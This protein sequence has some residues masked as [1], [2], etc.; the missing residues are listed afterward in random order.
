VT[1]AP[2]IILA[3]SLVLAPICAAGLILAP[4]RRS[5]LLLLLGV[6]VGVGAIVGFGQQARIGMGLV[7]TGGLA[8]AILAFGFDRARWPEHGDAGAHIPAGRAFRAATVLLVAAAA[9]GISVSYGSAIG[10]LPPARATAAMMIMAMGLLQLG[11]S[12][13]QGAAALGLLTTLAGFEVFYAGLEPSLALRAV[14]AGIMLGIALISSVLL[15]PSTAV[16]EGRR[17]N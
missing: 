13:E 10:G 3:I 15:E 1:S 4:T 8:C 14:L 17:V 6:F 7:V 9:W 11:L 2:T 5:A 12:Q 16:A